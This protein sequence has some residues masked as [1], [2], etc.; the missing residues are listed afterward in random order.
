MTTRKSAWVVVLVALMVAPTARGQQRRRQAE[1]ARQERI[2]A[3]EQANLELKEKLESLEKR[4][5]EQI[6]REVEALRQS[7]Q[8]LDKQLKELKG[9]RDQRVEQLQ[10]DNEELLQRLDAVEIRQADEAEEADRR[11]KKLQIYG[12][13]DFMTSYVPNMDEDHAVFGYLGQQTQVFKVGNLSLIVDAQPT[14]K[15]RALFETLFVFAPDGQ[16]ED[17]G[18]PVLGQSFKRTDTAYL[19][20]VSRVGESRW[21]GI[22]IDRAWMEWAPR[23]YFKIV[24]GKFFT[25]YGI[26]NLDHGSPV[27]IGVRPPL[28]LNVAMFPSR[29][30][31]IK[32]H[33]GFFLGPERLEYAIYLSNGRGPISNFDLDN[34]KSIG[35]RLQV[36]SSRL[37]ELK[38]GISGYWGKFT[39][40]EFNVDATKPSVPPILPRL[41]EEVTEQFKESVIGLD[42]QFD[43]RSVGLKAEFIR[44]VIRFSDEGRP[45]DFHNKAFAFG[46]GRDTAL[47]A[48]FAATTVYG[49]VFYQLPWIDLRP[50]VRLEWMDGNDNVDFD[51]TV[52]LTSGLNYRPHP[53]IVLKLEYAHHWFAD[54]DFSE[55]VQRQ[56]DI[57]FLESI[58][59]DIPVIAAQ[60]AVSF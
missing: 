29:Q 37:G 38:L 1:A 53:R 16:I 60:A 56:E 31:G 10:R 34:H 20:N 17:Y 13:F 30:T 45:V 14:D 48:D 22:V 49:T 39:D 28:L 42:L 3:L 44:S 15:W 26:W 8:A 51:H 54:R 36:A 43:Y 52:V 4:Q 58:K 59:R 24:G 47:I 11:R 9:R 57:L 50:Y 12:W 33:G 23:D 35:G 41:D 46:L 27:L 55:V 32:V 6:Q 40:T 7:Q 25:P 2:Q 5:A 18:V 19:D 21:G